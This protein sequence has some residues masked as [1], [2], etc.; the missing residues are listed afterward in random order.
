V[1]LYLSFAMA[2]M[3][4]AQADYEYDPYNGEDINELCAG[5]HGD[6]GEGGGDG[7]YPRLAGLPAKYLIKQLKA[8]NSGKRPSIAMAIYATDREL[9]GN[10]ILDISTYL[11]NIELLT[12][13]PL[14][15]EDM[16]ALEKLHLAGRVMNVA[17]HDGDVD[18]GR[19]IYAARCAKCHGVEGEGKGS[20]PPLVGQHTNYLRLQIESYKD[21]ERKNKRMEK[22]IMPLK[23]AEI[24]ALLAYLS[25]L[26]DTWE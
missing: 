25:V 23:A 17:R 9:P 6:L 21:G 3:A 16:P 13:M 20:T 2:S 1:I 4:L 15:D 5:C 24:E 7:F 8:F 11:A 14:V 12:A 10:D 22:Y 19:D 26:D 18:L